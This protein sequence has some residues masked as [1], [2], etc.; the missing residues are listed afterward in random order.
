MH[1]HCSSL[2]L[3]L[4][5]LTGVLSQHRK[6]GHGTVLINSLLRHVSDLPSCQAI[7]LHVQASNSAAQ[8]FYNQYVSS[9]FCGHPF[10]YCIAELGLENLQPFQITMSF[11]ARLKT[12]FST[13]AILMVVWHFHTHSEGT[14]ADTVRK[15]D[16]ALFTV[17]TTSLKL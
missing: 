6:Q 1:V 5:Q 12:H 3:L 2:Q 11:K 17:A 10:F 15:Q 14:Y 9:L 13:V 16:I 8:Y 4:S 7:Y